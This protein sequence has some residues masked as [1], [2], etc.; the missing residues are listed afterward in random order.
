MIQT[1]TGES[2]EFSN[3]DAVVRLH[4]DMRRYGITENELYEVLRSVRFNKMYKHSESKRALDMYTD[5]IVEYA[6]IALNIVGK[7]VPDVK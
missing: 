7:N 6:N 4:C 1:Q 5:S 2:S 3:E